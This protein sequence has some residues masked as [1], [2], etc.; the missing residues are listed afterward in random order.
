MLLLLLG[1]PP[2]EPRTAAD[3]VS[4][5]AAKAR[6]ECYLKVVEGVFRA[7]AAAAIALVESGITDQQ[8]RDFAWYKVTKDVDPSTNKYCD[9]IR[10]SVFADRCRLIV[11]RPHLSRGLAGPD[12]I[13]GA[14]R[15]VLDPSRMGEDVRANGSPPPP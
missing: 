12:A 2:A 8:N 6:D 5:G 7:D 14:N 11:G 4:I 1:C 10:D 3:C 9:R 15:R 13:P